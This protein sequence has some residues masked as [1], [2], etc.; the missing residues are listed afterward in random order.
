M[1][2]LLGTPRNTCNISYPGPGLASGC[3]VT[4][5]I[6]LINL[7]L[8]FPIYSEGLGRSQPCTPCICWVADSLLSNLGSQKARG[9]KALALIMHKGRQSPKRQWSL[10]PHNAFEGFLR[11]EQALGLKQFYTG[12]LSLT[13]WDLVPCTWRTV[14]T[15]FQ[16]AHGAE[17]STPSPTSIW[18][19]RS[20][21]L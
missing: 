17:T 4:A 3:L 20:Q 18:F 15:H 8:G 11:S 16:G 13:H 19:L 2:K 21:K 5:D 10:L 6:F 7:G 1:E 14:L 9:R 12:F